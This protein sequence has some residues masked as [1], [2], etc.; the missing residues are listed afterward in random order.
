MHKSPLKNEPSQKFRV[1]EPHLGVSR[2]DKERNHDDRCGC[3]HIGRDAPDEVLHELHLAAVVDSFYD[4][5]HLTRHQIN[6]DVCIANCSFGSC[7][8][9]MLSVTDR[10]EVNCTTHLCRPICPS[11]FVKL[12]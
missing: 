12:L 1:L 7:A 6:Q 11:D 10:G 8:S 4:S 2:G 3:Q 5:L 9:G